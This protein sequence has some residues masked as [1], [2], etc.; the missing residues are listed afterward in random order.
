MG[1]SQ[2]PGV[3]RLQGTRSGSLARTRSGF[4]RNDGMGIRLSVNIKDLRIGQKA[5][6]LGFALCAGE[7][8]HR[9]LSMGLT[10]GTVI[11]LI[12]I[13]PLGDP[14]QILVRGIMLSLRKAE[15]SI[16]KLEQV[17]A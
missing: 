1:R 6:I 5:K 7:Y 11:E 14:V 16:L 2:G 12:R 8:R 10:P 15:A 4:A 3:D 13:A 9:L 17:L